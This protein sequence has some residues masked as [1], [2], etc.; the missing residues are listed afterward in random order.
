MCSTNAIERRFR[1]V[2]RRT[3]PMATFQDKTP[4]TV[5][6]VFTHENKSQGISTPFLLTQTI[7]LPAR[8]VTIRLSVEQLGPSTG[9]SRADEAH[10]DRRMGGYFRRWPLWLPSTPTV[11]EG[12]GLPPLEGSQGPG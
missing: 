4:W 7:D 5:F 1:K 2:Q 6:A 10:G 12:D 3:R 11:V 8:G 9:R